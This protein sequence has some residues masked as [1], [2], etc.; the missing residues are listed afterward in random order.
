MALPVTRE[1]TEAD[2]I[3]ELSAMRWR[4]DATLR[5]AVPYANAIAPKVID[6][7]RKAADGNYLLPQQQNLLFWGIHLLAAG[8]CTELYRPFL[9]LVT[10]NREEFF[11]AL[12]GSAVTETLPRIVIST[13]DGDA[14]SLLEALANKAVD[15]YVRWSLFDALARLTFDGRIDRETSRN[16]L[17]RF[18]RERLAERDDAVWQGWV[19]AITHLG[20]EEL[21]DNVRRAWDDELI[22]PDMADRD[23]VEQRFAIAAALRPG[24][25]AMF[26][27]YGRAPIDDVVQALSWVQAESDRRPAKPDKNDPARDTALSDEETGWLSGFLTSGAVP[28]T[29]MTLEQLDGFFC[30]LLAGPDSPEASEYMPIIWNTGDDPDLDGEPHFGSAELSEYAEGLIARHWKS[31][32]LRLERGFPHE[33]V[34]DEP[35]A[36]E[37]GQYWA[38]GFIRGVAMRAQE[39]GRHTHVEDVKMFLSAMVTLG[40]DGGDADGERLERELREAIVDRL[41]ILVANIH[42]LLRGREQPFPPAPPPPPD[43]GRKI[44]RNERCPCGSGKKYKFCCGS[45]KSQLID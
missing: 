16:F 17:E 35:Y 38:A 24:D 33:V 43:F 5:R 28:E 25:P 41:P 37:I 27:Q 22:S 3:E 18:E 20:L 21:Y 12:L 19:D 11:D 44:G 42:H 1:A 10:R 34:I 26:V 36:M 40:S 30:A 2:I 23:L 4:S 29:A 7:V 8:R 32:A 9:Q 13:F 15:D 39:W 45:S 6:L 14:N 31:V